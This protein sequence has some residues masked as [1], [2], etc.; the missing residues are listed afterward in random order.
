[1]K[2]KLS[3]FLKKLKKIL[4]IIS[5]IIASVGI[6]VLIIKS[7]LKG[8]LGFIVGIVLTAILYESKTMKL[9]VDTFHEVFKETVNEKKNK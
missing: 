4:I 7:G 5:K 1:M 6:F 3:R 8:I 9:M 2:E